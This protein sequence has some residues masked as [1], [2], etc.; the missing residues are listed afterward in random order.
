M[1]ETV[2]ARNAWERLIQRYADGRPICN[3]GNAYYTPCGKG[4]VSGSEVRRTDLLV[5]KDGCQANQ[6]SVKFELAERI[7]AELSGPHKSGDGVKE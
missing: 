5:C 6:Y 2:A 3:C 4:F 1:T 7:E